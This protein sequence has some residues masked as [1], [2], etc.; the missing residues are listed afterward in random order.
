MRPKTVITLTLNPALDVKMRFSAPRLGALNRAQRMDVEPSGKGINVARALARLGIRVRAVA[1]LGG[2]FGL[3]IEQLVLAETGLELIGV[4]ITESTRC[5]LKVIDANSS[6]VTEFNAPGPA[7]TRE[8]W[9][10]IEA[11]LFEPLEE[12]DQVVLAGSLPAGA[13]STVYA[14]LV[15][16]THEIGASALLDTAG[17]ALREALPARPFLVK[18]NRLEAEELLGLPIRDRKDAIWAAQRIQALGAQHVV[19]SLGGDGAVFLSPKEG[20]W[21]HPPRVQV[22]STVGCGDALLAG[23]VAGILHQRPWPDGAR[24][25]TALAA[26]RA[27]GEGVEFP[28]LNRVKALIGEVRLEVL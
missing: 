28:D 8:E 16:K 24:F 14:S 11:A 6:E 22:K 15:Q 4:Q 19:L 1:P 2:S 7:L 17:A 18:P 13:S 21:A 5:N 20:V 27:G 12:G 23:V 9:K 26:A 25:A 10:R 3:A